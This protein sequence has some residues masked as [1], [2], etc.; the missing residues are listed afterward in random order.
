M[1]KE[2]KKHEKDNCNLSTCHLSLK[3]GQVAKH[4]QPIIVIFNHFVAAPEEN[5]FSTQEKTKETVPNCHIASMTSGFF[6]IFLNF[7]WGWWHV[8]PAHD[9]LSSKSNNLRSFQ[10]V[11]YVLQLDHGKGAIFARD[12]SGSGTTDNQLKKC[13]E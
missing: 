6:L 1:I 11:S 2:E 12:C 10:E 4:E 8:P 13:D 3:R 9:S 7:S 5:L